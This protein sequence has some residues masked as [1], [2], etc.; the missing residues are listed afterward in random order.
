MNNI[1]FQYMVHKFIDHEVILLI[2]PV[3]PSIQAQTKG[4]NINPMLSYYPLAHAAHLFNTSQYS[5]ANIYQ[6]TNM[7]LEEFQHI[8]DAEGECVQ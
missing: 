6:L 4:F 1:I 8:V 7:F 2:L 5:V 3:L